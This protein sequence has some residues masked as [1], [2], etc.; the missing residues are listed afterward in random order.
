MIAGM[1]SKAEVLLVDD[2]PADIDL[3]REI[4]SKCKLQ[5][6][7]NAVNDGVEAIS[8]LHRHGNYAEAPAPDLMVLDL[9]LTKKYGR[10][11]LQEL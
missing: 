6:H 3:T 2:N 7:V 10:A 4:L 9:N 8:Y 1:K 11:V 5:F